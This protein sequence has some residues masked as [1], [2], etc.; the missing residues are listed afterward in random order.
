[1]DTF[2]DF[3]DHG[4][5]SAVARLRETLCDSADTPRFVETVPRKGYRFVGQ[6]EEVEPPSAAEP[7]AQKVQ[8]PKES[9]IGS[10]GIWLAGFGIVVLL[11]LALVKIRGHAAASREIAL[12]TPE[13]VP[14]AGLC[15]LRGWAGVLSRRQPGCFP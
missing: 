2:V 5:N 4:L 15:R 11:A 7:V 12:P 1:M 10:Y 14:L 6:L 8:P 3:D 13:I 9:W